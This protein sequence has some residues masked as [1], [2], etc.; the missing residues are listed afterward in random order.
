MSDE[1]YNA[2][3]LSYTNCVTD[4]QLQITGESFMIRSSYVMHYADILR[5]V[6]TNMFRHGVDGRDGKRHFSLNIN[7]LCDR[8]EIVFVNDTAGE[9][10]QLNDIFK[11]KIGD[12]SYALG[13]GGSGLA[14]VE[15]I[16]KRDLSCQ[17]NV[18]TMNAENGKC[19]TSV[20]IYLTNFKAA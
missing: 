18:F 6:L 5:N 15:K 1:P 19:T 17:D 13:E 9:D 14:K 2:V 3:K 12:S 8:V 4:D 7:I 10:Q 20:I 16:L 11:R